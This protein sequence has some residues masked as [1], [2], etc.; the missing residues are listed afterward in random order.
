M[1]L[2]VILKPKIVSIME[3]QATW[4]SGEGGP[5]DQL[6]DRLIDRLTDQQIDQ[7]V[8]ARLRLR[9]KLL[10]HSQKYLGQAIGLTFQQIQKYERGKSRIPASRLWALGRVMRV[11]VSY[12]FDGLT[13][14]APFPEEPLAASELKLCRTLRR[15]PRRQRKT[16][17]NL[18]LAFAETPDPGGTP[19]AG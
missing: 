17:H 2:F 7:Y 16:L 1:L 15:L 9:R 18:I 4:H 8:G 3:T 10:G 19:V 5:A 12:F 14:N 6:T 11:P 13:E